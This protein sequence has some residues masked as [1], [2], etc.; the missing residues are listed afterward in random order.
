MYLNCTPL[1]VTGDSRL[2]RVIIFSLLLFAL[3]LTE[4]VLQRF[5]SLMIQLKK[6]KKFPVL[7]LMSLP[8]NSNKQSAEELV[9]RRSKVSVL[10]VRPVT[11]C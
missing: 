5:C 2:H 8:L 9:I 6:K 1:S 11:G 4:R 7:L 10:D 3:K